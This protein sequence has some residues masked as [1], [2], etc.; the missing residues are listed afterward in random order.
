MHQAVGIL[1]FIKLLRVLSPFHS[2]YIANTLPNNTLPN[3]TLSM[4]IMAQGE[5]FTDGN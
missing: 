1:N 3:N 5:V 4:L 2:T